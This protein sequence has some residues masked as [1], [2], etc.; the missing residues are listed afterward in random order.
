MIVLNQASKM[1]DKDT[2]TP[3]P[4]VT[5]A[6]EQEPMKTE[7]KSVQTNEV[8]AISES[9]QVEALEEVE[10]IKFEKPTT[11][12]IPSPSKSKK[13]PNMCGV[14]TLSI[15]IACVFFGIS[16]ILLFRTWTIL[17]LIVILFSL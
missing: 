16:S 11:P 10:S 5:S 14:L 2:K 12:E 13:D 3:T 8:V 9:T 7:T 4:P 15:G 17:N 1:N 6:N